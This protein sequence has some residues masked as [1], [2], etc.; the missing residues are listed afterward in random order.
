MSIEH[1]FTEIKKEK[2]LYDRNNNK[3]KK[4]DAHVEFK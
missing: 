4:N 3:K 1:F 2:K